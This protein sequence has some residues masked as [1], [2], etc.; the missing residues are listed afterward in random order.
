[1]KIKVIKDSV[2]E[3]ENIVNNWFQ[4]NDVDIKQINSEI[5]QHSPYHTIVLIFY[6]DKK[7]TDQKCY[8]ES[9][10]TTSMN[11]KFCGKPKYFHDNL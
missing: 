10:G 2:Y 5:Q 8:Y 1:M 11:C 3:L 7:I 9:D 6:E 4:N